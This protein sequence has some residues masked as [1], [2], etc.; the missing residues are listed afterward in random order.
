MWLR[1][2]KPSGELTGINLDLVTDFSR[3]VGAEVTKVRTTTLRPEGLHIIEVIE[4]V[5]AILDLIAQ[6][7]TYQSA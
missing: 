5:D 2:T 6:A 3:A 4:D 1:L 7:R